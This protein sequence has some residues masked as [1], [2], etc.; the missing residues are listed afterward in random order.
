M[1]N[2]WFLLACTYTSVSL[3]GRQERNLYC[4]VALQVLLMLNH[5]NIVSCVES[6]RAQGK[7]CIVMDFCSE[8]KPAHLPGARGF[9]LLAARATVDC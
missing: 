1:I 7:L 9:A 3:L 4:R 5:S 8:G 2:F 6:F